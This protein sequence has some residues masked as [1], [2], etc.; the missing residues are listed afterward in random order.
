MLRFNPP[1]GWDVPPHPWAPPSGFSKDPA[2]PE[3]PEGWEYWVDLSDL[4]VERNEIDETESHAEL[5]ER[6]EA[7]VLSRLLDLDDRIV[8]QEAGVYEYHHPLENAEAYKSELSKIREEISAQVRAGDAIHSAASFSF[9]NSIAKGRKLVNELSALALNAFNQEVE[10]TLRTLRA[11]TL[12]MALKRIENSR[13]KVSRFGK[14]MSLSISNSF[15]DL[16]IREIKLTADYLAKVQEQKEVQR[17]E[18]QRLR[19]EEKARKE[20]V[21]QQQNLEKEKLHYESALASMVAQGKQTEVALL[22]S[23]LAEIEEALVQN[24]YRLHNARAGYVYV[25]SNEGAFGAGVVKIGM[26]R[27]LD[28]MDRVN[29]LGDASVPFRFSVHT[30][31][32]A[33]DAVALE[34]KLHQRFGERRINVVNTRKEFFFVSA[35]EVLEALKNE[36][37]ALLEFDASP[38]SEEY[39]QSLG[40]WPVRREDRPL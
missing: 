34:G 5:R 29:E 14:M 20:L 11:G 23:R 1:P 21:A 16:R 10:N 9:E 32:F 17:E 30:L 33:D 36:T 15:M 12:S 40:T 8:L 31:F 6:V 28:P 19:E 27:R 24:D 18:R 39:L 3:A 26:T 37:G 7:E 2:W 13:D 22:E 35:E 4:P 38:T 25:I